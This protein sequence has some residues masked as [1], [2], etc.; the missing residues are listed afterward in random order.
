VKPAHRWLVLSVFVLSSTINYLD[1]QTL[2][3]L[4]PVLRAELRLSNAEYGWIVS[5]FSITY[6][7]CAPFAG[8]LIDRIGLYRGI[9]LAI[10][11]WSLADLSTGWVRGFGDLLLCRAMLGVAEAGGIPAAAKAIQQCLRPSERALGNS[12]NQA[13]VSLGLILAPPVATW[14][15]VHYGWRAAF[16]ATAFLG[17]LWIPLWRAVG[18]DGGPAAPQAPRSDF[19]HERRLW[20]FALANALSMVPYSLWTNWTT[21]HL[22]DV[23]R[24]S[25]VRAAWFAWLPPLFGALGGV[26]GGSLSF[27]WMNAGQAALTARTRVCLLAAIACLVTAV[28]PW[29]PTAA[30]AVAGISLSFFSVAAFSVNMYS[31]P[32][33]VFPAD[34]AAFAVSLLVSAYGAM[35]AVTSPVLGAVVDRYGYTPVCVTASIMPLVAVAI[36]KGTESRQ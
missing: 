1:R 19:P 30:L 35:Q 33:D 5:A 13:G 32:L 20:I 18:D 4:A 14:L 11:M 24:L 23:N 8:L 2:A 15:A 9:T 26:A 12:L 22:V 3:T 27:H 6:A 16:I 10:G 29:A 31:M 17:F 7:A 28:I 25:F 34:R 21:L 36:L